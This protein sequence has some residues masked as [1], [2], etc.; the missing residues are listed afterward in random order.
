MY[1]FFILLI[2]E[3]KLLRKNMR[4]YLQFLSW[5]N[6]LDLIYQLCIHWRRFEVNV[7]FHLML[8]QGI[9]LV[10]NFTQG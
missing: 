1:G 7:W 9:W 5:Y 6:F 8:F 10:N 2:E 3:E 4:D